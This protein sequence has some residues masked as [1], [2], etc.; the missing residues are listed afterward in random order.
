MRPRSSV[1]Q[2]LRTRLENFASKP[3]SKRNPLPLG[4]IGLV[5]AFG[6]LWFAFNPDELPFIGSGTTYSAFFSEDAG[7]KSGDD[8]RIAGVKVGSVASVSLDAAKV[9]VD[10][11]VKN[12]FVGNQSTAA[13]EIGTLLGA[14][15]LGVD[16]LGTAALPPSQTIPL[17]RT[18]S[19][20]DIYPALTQLTDTLDNI[21]TAQLAKAFDTLSDDLKGTPAD[22]RSAIEGLTRLSETVSSRDAQLQQLLAR[23]D[24]VT[25]V[26]ADRDTQLQKLLAD[27]GELLDELDSRRDAIHSLLLNTTDLSLQLEGLVADNQKT[28]GPLLNGLDSVLTLLQK[29]QDSLDQGLSLLGPYYRV[30]NNVVGNGRWFDSYIQNF[31]VPGI[32]GFLGLGGG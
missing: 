14:K 13:I 20:Y 6:I 2:T 27:G 32:G 12:A 1:L 25:G 29:N 24:Q 28:L 30:V 7:L 17:S 3:F 11:T 19:P 9:K 18:T 15:Y 10:F 16:S 23:A 8:V 5:L 26:L 4:V 31:S 22:V 21:D